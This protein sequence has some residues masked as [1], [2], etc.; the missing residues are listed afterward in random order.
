[1]SDKVPSPI[2]QALDN[3]CTVVERDVDS[4]ANALHAADQQMAGGKGDVWVGSAAVTWA[5]DLSGNARATSTKTRAFAAY[6]KKERD[7]HPKEVTPAEA[8]AERR[9]LAMPS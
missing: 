1:M 5:T 3:L 7:G 4:V 2:W 6:L 8:D 9:Q